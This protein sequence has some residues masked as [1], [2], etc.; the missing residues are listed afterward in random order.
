MTTY[1]P[2]TMLTNSSSPRLRY[3]SRLPRRHLLPLLTQLRDLLRPRK[4]RP[5]QRLALLSLHLPPPHLRLR[6]S[7]PSQ[8][9]RCNPR[10][11]T[12][13]RTPPPFLE[14]ASAFLRPVVHR[15]RQPTHPLIWPPL[16]PPKHPRSPLPAPPLPNIPNQNQRRLFL[17]FTKRRHPPCSAPTR[18]REILHGSPVFHRRRL[19]RV[20]GAVQFR[21]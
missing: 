10:L 2:M 15:H 18:R 21:C 16:P 19:A 14:V 3:P 12:N 11:P 4:R 1:A 5:R 9:P 13:P 20:Q 6:T 8:P 7:R 17:A